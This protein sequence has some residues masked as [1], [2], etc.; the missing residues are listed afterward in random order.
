MPRKRNEGPPVPKTPRVRKKK[1]DIE[2]KLDMSVYEPVM[3]TTGMMMEEGMYTQD[4]GYAYGSQ[5]PA[6]PQY[7]TD[8]QSSPFMTPACSTPQPIM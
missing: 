7:S 1:A 3:Q 5:G 6:A 2:K 8:S 4:Y